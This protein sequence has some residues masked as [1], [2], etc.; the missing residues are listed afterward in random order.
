MQDLLLLV[1]DKNMEFAVEGALH[2]Y[3]ALSIR[4]IGFKTLIHPG[5]DPGV[6]LTGAQLVALE[7]HQFRHA[8]MILDYEGSGSVEKASDL[9]SSL[10]QE[11]EKIWGNHA[12]AIVIEPELERW[13]WGSDSALEPIIDWK[14]RL[15]PRDWLRKQ[16]N[17]HLFDNDDKPLR[18]KEAFEQ[19]LRKAKTPRS[20]SLYREVTSKISVARCTDPAFLRLRSALQLWFPVASP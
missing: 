9:E 10:D 2:R 18:P 3:Q 1:A 14:E 8:C 20:S 15:S 19:V 13:L 12:K 7:R 11:I 16:S 17:A 6:R 5:R 4:Q